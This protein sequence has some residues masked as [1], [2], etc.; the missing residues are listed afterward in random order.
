MRNEKATPFEL[1]EDV[2]QLIFI[3][4]IPY[5]ILSHESRS[6]YPGQL[7]TLVGNIKT[8][9]LL[10]MYLIYPVTLFMTYVI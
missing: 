9:S 3:T 5:L 6:G 8:Q 4:L 1:F 2:F 10:Q 7:L